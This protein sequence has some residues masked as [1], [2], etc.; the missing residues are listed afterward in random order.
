MQVAELHLRLGELEAAALRSSVQRSLST[1]SSPLQA[2]AMA[3]LIE[4]PGRSAA[5]VAE[6]DALQL[7]QRCS[8]LEAE[9]QAL[10]RQLSDMHRLNQ[11][12]LQLMGPLSLLQLHRFC[13]GSKCHSCH[14]SPVSSL[15]QQTLSCPAEQQSPVSSSSQLLD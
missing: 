9:V 12:V 3:G 11:G 1:P 10:H 5:Q 7:R 2:P 15:V 14:S 4:G 13:W 8:A 6:R